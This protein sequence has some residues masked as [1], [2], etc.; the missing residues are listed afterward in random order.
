MVNLNVACIIAT[1]VV[2]ATSAAQDLD[3]VRADTREASRQATLAR[4][5]PAMQWTDW[6]L[7]GPFDN[8]D[9][10]MHDVVYPPELAIDLTGVYQGK[11]GRDVR[12]QS[13][14]HSRWSPISLKRFGDEADNTNGIAYL[15][16]EVVADRAAD[17]TFEVGSDDGVKLWLNG[18]LLLDADVYRGLNVQDHRIDLPLVKGRNTLLV[19]VTQGVGGWDFQMRPKVDGRLIAQLDYRLDQDFPGSPEAR[20]Y[21]LLSILEP[22]GVFLEVGGLDVL[23]DSRP[24]VAT[25]RGEVWII[26]GAY[27]DPPFDATFTLFASGLHEPLGARWIDDED[28]GSLY[29]AQRGELTRLLDIDGDDRAD[30][31]ETVSD[32]WG[33]SGNY[34]EYAFGPKLDGEGRM[35][36]TLCVGFCGQLGKSIVPWRG[37]AVI[38]NPDGTVDPVCGG[39]RAPNGLGR[40]AAGDMFYTDNQGDWVATCKLSHLERGDWHGHPSSDRWYEQAGLDQPDREKDFKPPAVWFPYG[41]MGQSSSDILLDDTGGAFGPFE[42]QLFVGDQTNA[43]I[44]RVDLERIDGVYQGACFPFRSGLAC[45]VNRMQFA[46]DGSMLAGLTN[47]GWGSLGGRSWGLQRVVYTGVLPFEVLHMRVTP[48]GFDLEFTMPVD[49]ETAGQPSSYELGS[50]T[51]NRFANYGSPEIDHERHVITRATVSA[52]GRSV[53]LTVDGLRTGYV[54]EL[55]LPGVRSAGGEALLHDEAYYTVN[56]KP[57]GSSQ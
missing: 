14:A 46:D 52:D 19:K 40:N 9:L 21:R 11:D 10:L 34:H 28:G 3:Y 4:Y 8:T 35:W 48:D 23:P 20:H 45:G 24:I 43:S 55:N 25:R 39:L 5:M 16:R 13:F 54:H 42:G 44:M 26:D 57:V 6:H 1:A 50:F 7:I 51:Y 18:R 2:T 38:I 17:V 47:R 49:P 56:R 53:R 41:R 36:V 31:Y 33:I 22:P 12:W 32:G 37:W 29:V 27:D 15:Y 30:L